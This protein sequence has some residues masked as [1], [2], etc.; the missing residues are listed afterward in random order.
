MGIFKQ[1]INTDYICIGI[2]GPTKGLGRSKTLFLGN[3]QVTIFTEWFT[4]TSW[5]ILFCYNKKGF[6]KIP[7]KII[8]G[9]WKSQK[10]S[11]STR[12]KRAT[13]TFWVDK[14]S[15]KEA[16]NGPIWR[17]FENLML[18]VKQ[19]YQTGQFS[20]AARGR[21]EGPTERSVFKFF[22]VKLANFGWEL[23]T[24]HGQKTE[25]KSLA[26]AANLLPPRKG[27]WVRC[28]RWQSGFVWTKNHATL[29]A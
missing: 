17:V 15:L 29:L 3:W 4:P 23:V 10:K 25:F 5:A 28:R 11:H 16:K 8:H 27:E 19:S 9:V 2:V 13:F 6:E 18:A 14:S 20:K 22:F 26:A 21:P 7:L 24:W 1:G 12:A